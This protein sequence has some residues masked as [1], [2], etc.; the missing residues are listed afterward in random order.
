VSQPHPLA[1]LAVD[2]TLFAQKLEPLRETM[3]LIR[4]SRE[5]FRE[6]SFLDDRILTPQT[7]GVWARHDDVA[8]RLAGAAA[9]PLHFIFHAGHAGSTLVSRLLD[10]TGCVQPL[11][12][13]PPLRQLAELQDGLGRPE[14]LVSEAQWAVWLATQIALWRRGWPE[15][16]AVILKA[17]SSAARLAARL[18]DAAPDARAIHLTLACEPYLAT[19]LAGANTPIDLRGMGGE[20]IRRLTA[21]LGEA[22]G[23]LHALSLGELAAM[24]WLAERLTQARL[25]ATHGAR[26]R[27]VDF[28]ALL[29]D[30]PGEMA[31]IAVHFGLAAPPGWAER[32]PHSRALATYSKAP[33]HPYSPALRAQILAEARAAHAAQIRAG[34]AWLERLGARH[35]EVAAVLG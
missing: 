21:Y 1:G 9:K 26:L 15:C 29:A 16:D 18:L 32:L 7:R 8:A 23:A 13:P 4:M 2:S 5:A 27:V 17:T 25:A 20:R 19:L 34:L 3:L 10:E 6:A 11:R 22:P 28:D 31:A 24:T 33:E 14:S 12:E 30:P 35:R